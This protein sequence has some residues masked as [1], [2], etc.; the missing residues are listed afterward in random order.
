MKVTADGVPMQDVITAVKLAIKEASVSAV[1]ERRDLRVGSVSLVLHALAARS[2][3][4]RLSFTIPFIGM[5]V[6][7]GAKVTRSDTH[8][9]EINL[10]PPAEEAGEEVRE[11]SLDLALAGSIET[12]RGVLAAAA[13]GDDP[14][15]LSDAKIT[16][17]FAVTSDGEISIGV[18]GAMT[19]EVTHTL[20]LTFVPA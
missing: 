6:R 1:S 13:D 11:A 9:I 14:F 20:V 8:E 18:D 3:G 19:G 10:A 12:I 2:A 16:L 17:S 4:G 5:P 15:I 7:F